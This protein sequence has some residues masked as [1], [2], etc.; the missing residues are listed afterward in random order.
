[1][2]NNGVRHS[3]PLQVGASKVPLKLAVGKAT[4]YSL[5]Q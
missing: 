5:G 1:M 4:A 3:H 2:P